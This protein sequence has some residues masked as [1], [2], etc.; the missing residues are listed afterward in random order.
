M[1]V[2]QQFRQAA[3][4]RHYDEAASHADQI[5]SVMGE[6]TPVEVFEF[7]D[8]FSDKSK[9]AAF[10]RASTYL[11]RE[12]P[13]PGFRMK[14]LQD[15]VK[16]R[17]DVVKSSAYFA[18]GVETLMHGADPKKAISPLKKSF[19]YG[20]MDSCLVLADAYENG[21][22]GQRG[23]LKKAFNILADAADEGF[24]PAKL[25]LS[26]FVVNHGIHHP[27]YHPRELLQEAAEEGLDEAV[28]LLLIMDDID[29]AASILPY[30][31]VPVSMDRPV[32][33]KNAF[34]NESDILPEYA[35]ELIA[36]LYGFK[37]WEALT[38]AVNS[39]DRFRARLTRIAIQMK[40]SCED[41]FNYTYWRI[42]LMLFHRFTRLSGAFCDRLHATIVL[43]C[44]ILTRQLTSSWHFIPVERHFLCEQQ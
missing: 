11:Y 28:T 21:R 25:A 33:I 19:E 16:S 14:L 36:K 10:V 3:A 13:E 44:V 42:I 43:L 32:Q 24:A 29:E 23:H 7:L 26:K 15:A 34:L 22:F 2:M 37:T 18:I 12:E 8:A 4:R 39:P 38:A 20:N 40:W 30:E 1:S 17:D 9:H 27:D 6:D 5:V 35:E 41:S 31:V